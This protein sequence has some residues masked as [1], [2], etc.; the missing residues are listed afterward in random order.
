MSLFKSRFATVFAAAVVLVVFSSLSAVGASMITSSKIKNGTIR[1]VD[2][3]NGTL[4]MRDLNDHTRGAIQ[5][6]G[7]SSQ[8]APQLPAPS[9]RTKYEGPNWSIID[10]NVIGNGD[11]YL[12]SGPG[13]PPVGM[14]SLGLRTG[15]SSDK[16]VFGD[17]SD[18]YGE[19]LASL[20]TLKYSVFATG[21]DLGASPINLPNL[22]FEVNPHL[23]GSGGTY[24][25][26]IFVPTAGSASP[27][28]WSELDA[29]TAKQWYL[30]GNGPEGAGTTTGCNDAN[31]CT[32][33]QVKAAAPDATLL[34]AQISKGRDWAFS[35]AVDKLVINDTTYDF[36]PFGVSS[37]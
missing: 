24:S 12:R 15:S 16:A 18:F 37:N 36:E 11:S 33:A 3:R 35:G 7:A 5:Q 23:S 30:T 9:G 13:T 34:T 10:R 8:G 32:L 4:G 1:S 2:V 27:N 31:Y 22:Q 19:T 17:Q 20:S 21:E 26:L 14:G 28:A 25:T 6:H 29:S